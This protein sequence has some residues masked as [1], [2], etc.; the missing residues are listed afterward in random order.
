[1]SDLSSNFNHSIVVMPNS[2]TLVCLSETDAPEESIIQF[3]GHYFKYLS[4]HK[5]VLNHLTTHRFPQELVVNCA[6][7]TR[8]TTIHDY[9]SLLILHFQMARIFYAGDVYK[10]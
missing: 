10:K 8:W 9:R 6:I 3:Y 5:I 1:M 4:I 2:N 7:Y